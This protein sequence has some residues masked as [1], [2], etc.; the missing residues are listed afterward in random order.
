MD[1]EKI[2]EGPEALAQFVSVWIESKQSGEPVDDDDVLNKLYGVGGVSVMSALHE[3]IT[4]YVKR[5]L[6]YAS[7]LQAKIIIFLNS[8][9]FQVGQIADQFGMKPQS[10]SNIL[11]IKGYAD[12]M[13]PEIPLSS[14]MAV[15]SLDDKDRKMVIRKATDEG[16]SSGEVRNLVASIKSGVPVEEIELRN[17]LSE[18]KFWLSMEGHRIPKSL[19]SMVSGIHEQCESVLAK[20]ED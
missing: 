13:N 6:S 17:K 19:A 4:L 15:S 8:K 5:R 12:E 3:S 14:Y 9:G 10:V 1:L 18:F 20:Y 11:Q 16:M 7:Q 2:S